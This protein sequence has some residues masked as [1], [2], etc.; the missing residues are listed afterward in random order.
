[1]MPIG[2]RSSSLVL[3]TLLALLPACLAATAPTGSGSATTVQPSAVYGRLP[4]QFEPN[5]GQ[6]DP[7][8]RFVARSQGISVFLED[9]AASL[10]LGARN[11]DGERPAVVRME[12]L[13][14]GS[15]KSIAGADRRPGIANYFRGQDPKQSSAEATE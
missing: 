4:L 10:V 8:V 6:T 11:A 15:P 5:Q 13:G 14:A 1:M 2:L 3:V 9:K 7:R 12:L